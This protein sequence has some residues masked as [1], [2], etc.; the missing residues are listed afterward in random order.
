MRSIHKALVAVSRGSF[1]A[2][3]TALAGTNTVISRGIS[4]GIAI[5][6]AK[7]EQQAQSPAEQNWKTRCDLAA[8]YRILYN[9]NYHEGVCNHLS[10]TCPTKDGSGK[11]MLT[12]PYGL[13]WRE[14]T[15]TSLVGTSLEIATDPVVVEKG[16]GEP[17]ISAISI[18]NGVHQSRSDMSCLLHSHV[19]NVTALACL[20]DPT[21]L[22][23]HQNSTRFLGELCYDHDYDGVATGLDEGFRLAKV[24]GKKTVMLMANHGVLV[25]GKTVAEAFDQLYYLER[26]AEVQVSNAVPVIGTMVHRNKATSSSAFR[27]ESHWFK[28]R[29]RSVKLN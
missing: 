3:Q 26:A 13:S 1:S 7:A 12:I 16:F 17:D 5:S 6:S 18:H 11:V 15:A 22:M 14:V 23:C 25:L 20:K 4:R 2:N 8:S 28:P 24:F 27:A 19:P 21:L 9:L 10:A 29:P